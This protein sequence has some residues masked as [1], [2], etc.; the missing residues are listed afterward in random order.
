MSKEQKLSG[1]NVFSSAVVRK[2]QSILYPITYVES[3]TQ[4]YKSN[5]MEQTCCLADLFHVTS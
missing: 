4:I 2:A 1:L 5:E 3:V